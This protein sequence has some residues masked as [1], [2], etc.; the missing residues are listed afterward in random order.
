MLLLTDWFVDSQ[1]ACIPKDLKDLVG[2]ETAF[3]LPLVHKGVD[4]G[5]DE[6]HTQKDT[7]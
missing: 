1:K 5:V 4:L 2:R 7:Y 6:L 3:G